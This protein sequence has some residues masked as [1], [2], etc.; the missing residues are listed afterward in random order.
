MKLSARSAQVAWERVYRARDTRLNR[1][2]VLKVLPTHLSDDDAARARF[3]REAR[4]IAALSHPN[5]CTL[6]DVGVAEG[7]PP[8]ATRTS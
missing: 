3:D 5:I 7:G 4:A 2:F 8:T 6:F 1:L